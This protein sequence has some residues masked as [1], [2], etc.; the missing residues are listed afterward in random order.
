MEEQGRRSVIE[1][2]LLA[3]LFCIAMCITRTEKLLGQKH[4][5]ALVNAIRVVEPAD[6]PPS[7]GQFADGKHEFVPSFF[8][9][10]V[11]RVVFGIYD[12]QK[13]GSRKRCTLRP[14]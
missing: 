3:T 6:E 4:G 11:H 12:A 5:D 14:R 2:T 8:Q 7:A 13:P 10:Q 9:R 1:S